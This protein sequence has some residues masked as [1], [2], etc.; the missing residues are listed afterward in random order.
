[1]KGVV[2][3]RL[4]YIMAP[5]QFNVEVDIF[6]R[7]LEWTFTFIKL[8]RKYLRQDYVASIKL[9]LKAA[10]ICNHVTLSS[11]YTLFFI[12]EISL[13]IAA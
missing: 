8:G 10:L 9:A 3:T 1:M 12:L 5:G 2:P 7:L 4:T 13:L 11:P 6:S